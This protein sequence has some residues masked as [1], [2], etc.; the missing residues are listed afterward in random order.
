MHLYNTFAFVKFIHKLS[1]GN[2]SN[3]FHGQDTNSIKQEDY[4]GYDAEFKSRYALFPRLILGADNFQFVK[5]NYAQIDRSGNPVDMNKVLTNHLFP[6]IWY[7]HHELE[8]VAGFRYQ[9]NYI[10]YEETHPD[11]SI[12]DVY[13][14]NLIHNFSHTLKSSLLYKYGK[15]YFKQIYPDYTVSQIS[16]RLIKQYS[17]FAFETD[18]GYQIR[19]FENQ[20]LNKDIEMETLR[21]VCMYQYPIPPDPMPVD[22]Y[23]TTYF[24]IAARQYLDEFSSEAEYF[25]ARH[26]SLRGGHLFLEKISVEFNFDFIKGDFTIFSGLTP[27]GKD[28][29]REDDVYGVIGKVGYSLTEWLNLYFKVG[30][31]QRDSNIEDFDYLKKV[32]MVELEFKYRYY[33]RKYSGL[34]FEPDKRL[35]LF[36]LRF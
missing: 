3:S 12:E 21:A 11:E 17:H 7:I 8:L 2:N 13:F 33:S 6:G 5:R 28:A 25:K 30:Y 31:K 20:T 1:C 10:N 32:F 35:D 26:L 22:Y 16:G 9:N 14:F 4:I 18:L 19:K 23:P 15:R 27:E 36:N 34:L 29:L 24:L